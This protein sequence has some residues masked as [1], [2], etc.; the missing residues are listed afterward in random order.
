M[1]DYWSHEYGSAQGAPPKLQP[2]G[3]NQSR[4]DR[5]GSNA[6]R[7]L[8]V[9]AIFRPGVLIKQR[10]LNVG[11]DFPKREALAGRQRC[12]WAKSIFV[13]HAEDGPVPLLVWAS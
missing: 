7:C 12:L 3:L 11:D 4:H 1:A 10:T 2:P 9:F 6:D 8:R 13:Q 5:I